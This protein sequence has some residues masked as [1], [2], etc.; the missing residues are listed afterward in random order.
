MQ[1]SVILRFE[2]IFLTLNL[3]HCEA[4]RIDQLEIMSEKMFS[5]IHY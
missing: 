5:L 1:L 2:S 3:Q 4:Y